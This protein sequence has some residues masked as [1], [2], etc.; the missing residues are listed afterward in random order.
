MLNNI[1]DVLT[2]LPLH[3]EACYVCLVLGAPASRDNK[4]L[5]IPHHVGGWLL[6]VSTKVGC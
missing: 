1:Y 5:F 6:A 4:A 3:A 2:L